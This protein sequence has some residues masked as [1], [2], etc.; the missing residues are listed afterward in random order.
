MALPPLGKS[1]PNLFGLCAQT[2]KC[3]EQ[4]IEC[5]ALKVPWD[6]IHCPGVP[7]EVPRPGRVAA[8][9]AAWRFLSASSLSCFS[10][11]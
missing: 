8:A 1:V 11:A 4:L 5:P 6:T 7:L 3:P 10:R 2:A 9:R